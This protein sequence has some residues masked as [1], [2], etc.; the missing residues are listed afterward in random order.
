MIFST[1]VIGRASVVTGAGDTSPAMRALLYVK[2][3]PCRT[4]S[5]LIG[6]SPFVNSSIEI[7]SPRLMRSRMEKSVVVSS[8]MFWQ[9][10]P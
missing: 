10:C 4:T 3:P 7:A 1:S 9:F 2:R 6:S 8:P 5:A